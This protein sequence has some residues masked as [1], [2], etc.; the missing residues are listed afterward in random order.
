MMKMME[1]CC[2]EKMK[3][4]SSMM[5]SFKS[6]CCASGEDDGSKESGTKKSAE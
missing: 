6:G 3:D 5:S 2:P 4:L 1:K